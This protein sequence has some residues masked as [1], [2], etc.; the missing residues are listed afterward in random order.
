MLFLMPNVIGLLLC[1]NRLDACPYH[2]NHWGTHAW[3]VGLISLISKGEGASPNTLRPIGIMSV[4]YRLWAA[5]RVKEVMS[6]QEQWLDGGLHGF[7]KSHGAEDVWWS[8]ALQVESALL[9][10]GTLLGISLD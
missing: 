9:H 2:F 4:V 7:R 10:S 8:L 3:T 6:W 5:T 1:E